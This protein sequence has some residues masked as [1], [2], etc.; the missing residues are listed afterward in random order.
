MF[1]LCTT[2][3]KLFDKLSDSNLV[4]YFILFK[5]QEEQ[6]EFHLYMMA[7]TNLQI[8]SLQTKKNL[9]HHAPLLQLV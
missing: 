6:F 8:W 7:K 9:A 4:S 2:H 1:L 3:I 5:T